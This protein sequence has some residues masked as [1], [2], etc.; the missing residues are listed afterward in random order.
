[1]KE[2]L[3]KLN[4]TISE[5]S[6]N[7]ISSPALES[8]VMHLET[9]AGQMILPC[10]QAPVPAKDSVQAG[11]GAA[12]QISVIYGLHGSGSL[13]SAR[14]TQSL[15]NKFRQ[16]TGS[17][18]STLFRLTWKTRVTPSG[19]SIPALRASGRRTS[20]TEFISWPTPSAN[21]Y[22]QADQKALEARRERC[23]IAT[24]NGNGFGMTLGNAVRLATWSTPTAQDHSRGGKPARPWDTGVPLSQQAALAAWSAPNAG[25]GTGG[26][27][28]PSRMNA[29]T[30]ISLKAQ[31][32]NLLTDSGETQN[33]STA[34]T[35]NTGR[36]SPAHSR[37]LMGL[38]TEWDDCAA[39]VTRS[40][41]KSR[42]HSSKAIST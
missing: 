17:L 41:R 35:E 42:K 25:D 28:S 19:R 36:L 24:G 22:E 40:T 27:I 21:N 7:V 15:A 31:A 16:K 6:H 20:E 29:G 33:G 14:L 23:R 30:G 2:A 38:P 18:G 10:G 8:G 4:P 12:S 1:M 3:K 9:L 39:M 5:D 11:K 26:K 13:E 32:R 34:E 37:G